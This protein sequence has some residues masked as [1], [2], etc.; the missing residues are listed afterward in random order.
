MSFPHLAGLAA[1]HSIPA[2]DPLSIT[3]PFDAPWHEIQRL[4]GEGLRVQMVEVKIASAEQVRAIRAKLPDAMTIYYEVSFDS[5]SA[6]LLSA[7]S[8]AGG[9]A[10]LRIGGAAA[11][12]F[13]AP[14]TLAEALQLLAKHELGFKAT[15]G[16]H[17]P[18]RSI[19]PLTN[20]QSSARCFMHG[21]VNLMCAATLI[22]LG[23]T[24]QDAEEVLMEEDPAAFLITRGFIQWQG[25]RWSTAQLREVRQSFL[26]SI[27]SCSFTEPMDE[28]EAL[29]W[30]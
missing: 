30:L 28:L 1:A 6:D 2:P 29:G 11:E 8:L 4:Q 23:G 17:H 7:I 21:F 22:H 15:A 24:A 13:P 12:A 16:L 14:L 26:M 5:L 3:G 19:Q 10:K 18:L 9:R 20:Q 27:G 25:H